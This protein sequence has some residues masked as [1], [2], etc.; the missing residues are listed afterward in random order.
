M[1]STA[2]PRPERAAYTVQE[3]RT[4]LGGIA[5]A[6]I[7]KLIDTGELRTFRIGRRRLIGVDAIRDYIARAEQRALNIA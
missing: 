5:H 4:L 2:S 3:A 7:Y 1:T 6:T